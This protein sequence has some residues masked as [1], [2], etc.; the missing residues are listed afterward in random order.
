MQ[1]TV[2]YSTCNVRKLHMG[3]LLPLLQTATPMCTTPMPLASCY[4]LLFRH[5]LQHNNTTPQQLQSSI[6]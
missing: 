3:L 4:L 5:I 2:S 1:Y 6:M